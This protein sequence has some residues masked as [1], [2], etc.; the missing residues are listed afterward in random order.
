MKISVYLSPS[1]CDATCYIIIVNKF[2][3]EHELI[4]YQSRPVSEIWPELVLIHLKASIYSPLP[5]NSTIATMLKRGGLDA[6]VWIFQS[7]PPRGKIWWKYSTD[8]SHNK[9]MV[10]SLRNINHYPRWEGTITINI[11]LNSFYWT[12]V[13][14]VNLGCNKIQIH[15]TKKN[16]LVL[17]L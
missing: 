6:A 13:N 12:R 2:G 1:S 11:S 8:A 16:R 15:K 3:T 7:S 9:S 4:Y 5:S 14:Q 10:N 17:S